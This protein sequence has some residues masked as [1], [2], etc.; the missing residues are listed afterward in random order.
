MSPAAQNFHPGYA[1]ARRDLAAALVIGGRVPQSLPAQS[2]Y[3]DV[4]D[5]R[6]MLF[7]ES[8]QSSPNGALFYD[9]A[10]GTRFQ[11]DDSVNRLVAAVAVV[12]A[13]GLAAE[14]DSKKNVPLAFFDA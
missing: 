9:A 2:N 6:T 4:R 11:P 7:V 14:A 5:A 10:P 3:S 8:V 1:A 13:A 12:R